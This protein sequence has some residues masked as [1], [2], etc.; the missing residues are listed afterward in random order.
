MVGRLFS[1]P[2]G[3]F[4]YAEYPDT[5]GVTEVDFNKAYNPPFAFNAYSTCPMPP[6]NNRLDIA[7]NAGEKKPK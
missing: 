5:T 3:R 7:I 1:V 4:L 6:E 2:A